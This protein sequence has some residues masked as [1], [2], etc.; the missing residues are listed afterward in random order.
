MLND[1]GNASS[2]VSGNGAA[3]SRIDESDFFKRFNLMDPGVCKPDE[4]KILTEFLNPTGKRWCKPNRVKIY[5]EAH[6]RYMDRKVIIIRTPAADKKGKPYA[7]REVTV[8]GILGPTTAG[9]SSRSYYRGGAGHPAHSDS[10][11][12]KVVTSREVVLRLRIRLDGSDN[13]L[14]LS[15]EQVRLVVP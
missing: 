2:D 8:V 10:Y 15:T 12:S 3:T 13:T 1:K 7:G 5:H 11:Q 6:R 4:R 14:V 9:Q